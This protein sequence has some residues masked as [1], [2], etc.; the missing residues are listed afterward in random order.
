MPRVTTWKLDVMKKL[1]ASED[2]H[3]HT[4]LFSHGFG[5][6]WISQCVGNI[7]KL[8]KKT[9]SNHINQEIVN[10]AN[11]PK[12]Q[13]STINSLLGKTSDVILPKGSDNDVAKNFSTFFEEKIMKLRHRLGAACDDYMHSTPSLEIS[14][15]ASNQFLIRPS[16]K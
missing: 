1:L 6:V 12:R 15:N 5:F 7:I 10:T 3:V 8:I 9:R 16:G 11:N 4:L 13:F 2:A 14:L